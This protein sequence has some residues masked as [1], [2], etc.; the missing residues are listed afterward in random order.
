MELSHL[1]MVL[2]VIVVLLF[3][4]FYPTTRH[5]RGTKPEVTSLR[6]LSVKDDARDDA[7][8]QQLGVFYN[9]LGQWIIN[10][11]KH[12]YFEEDYPLCMQL[13]SWASMH[14]RALCSVYPDL[15]KLI[16]ARL[17]MD[18]HGFT[19]SDNDPFGDAFDIGTNKYRNEVRLSFIRKMQQRYNVHPISRID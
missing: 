2:A 10:D 16:Q 19:G 4:T 13:R 5:R 17:V 12:S 18:L 1:L 6:T 7:I 3:I 15:D 14:S 8:Y 9:Q 11:F